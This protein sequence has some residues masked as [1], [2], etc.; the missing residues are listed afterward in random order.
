MYIVRFFWL[1]IYEN[2]VAWGWALK[3]PKLVWQQP[4]FGLEIKCLQFHGIL[5]VQNLGILSGMVN[6]FWNQVR[7]FIFQSV[8]I[9]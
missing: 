1:L 4:F 5:S 3:L 8:G 7:H 6:F 9:F 2:S